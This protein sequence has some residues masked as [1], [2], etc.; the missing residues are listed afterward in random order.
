[1]NPPESDRIMTSPKTTSL[2]CLVCDSDVN[3]RFYFGIQCC[4]AC[5]KFYER[6]LSVD[7]YTNYTCRMFATCNIIGPKNRSACQAC[8]LQSCIKAGM[9]PDHGNSFQNRIVAEGVK[10][11]EA[12][13]C[14]VC[15]SHSNGIHF[16]LITC[17]GCKVR[18]WEKTS[19]R[20]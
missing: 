11:V 9:K 13:K 16:G 6:S 19:Q 7:G 20:L 5:K 18:F 4:E 2:K 12:T 17:E 15:G 1:M 14:T 10:L 8:R 3:V